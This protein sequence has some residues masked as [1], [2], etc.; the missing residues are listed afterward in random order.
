VTEVNGRLGK[1]PKGGGRFTL[2]DGKDTWKPNPANGFETP[3]VFRD[4][5]EGKLCRRG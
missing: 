1:G 4:I 2:R 3:R 5:R